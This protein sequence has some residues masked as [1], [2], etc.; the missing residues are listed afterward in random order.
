MSLANLG[1]PL[2]LTVIGGPLDS[3]QCAFNADYSTLWGYESGAGEGWFTVNL[4]TGAQSP[5]LWESNLSPSDLGGSSFL[6]LNGVDCS[7]QTVQYTSIKAKAAKSAKRG[8][9]LRYRASVRVDNKNKTA[10]SI[11]SINNLRLEVSRLSYE[12]VNAS[13]AHYI[14]SLHQ[15]SIPTYEPFQSTAHYNQTEIR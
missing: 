15:Y 3:Y 6:G 8:G 13:T 2:P 1:A 5:Y 10:K 11:K 12:N 7:T 4:Q 14:S 9:Y